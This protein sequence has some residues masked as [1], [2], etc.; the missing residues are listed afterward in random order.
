M[1]KLVIGLL[2]ISLLALG[3]YASTSIPKVLPEGKTIEDTETQT[4]ITDVVGFPEVEEGY[5]LYGATVTIKNVYPGWSGSG[6][7][8]GEQVRGGAG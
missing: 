2:S 1:R 5:G 3:I 7:I 4:T 8:R 6:R